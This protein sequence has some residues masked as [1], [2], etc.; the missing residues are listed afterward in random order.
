MFGGNDF[1]N[2]FWLRWNHALGRETFA[3]LSKHRRAP[4]LLLPSLIANWFSP[5]LQFPLG[6]DAC[7][8]AP[9]TLREQLTHFGLKKQS[10]RSV[11]ARGPAAAPDTPSGTICASA[12]ENDRIANW[13]GLAFMLAASTAVEKHAKSRWQLPN[14][15]TGET[16][17]HSNFVA[18]FL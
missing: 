7:P 5:P 3:D 13:T 8:L 12:A 17:F 18:G 2:A 4:R 1:M 11:A 15:R 14:R 16:V 9:V 6:T 10:A